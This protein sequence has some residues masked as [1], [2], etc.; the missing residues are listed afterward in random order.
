[1][2]YGKSADWWAFGVFIFELNSGIPPFCSPE[3]NDTNAL[4]ELI[5]KGSFEIPKNFTAILSDICQRL[6]QKEVS[7]RLGCLKRGSSDIRDHIWFDQVDWIGIYK[8]TFPSPYV[9]KPKEPLD[10]AF[11]NPNKKEDPL[12]ISKINQYKNEF[13]DF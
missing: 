10:I 9:P 2:P 1:M 3:T 6:I 13:I 12:K 5:Q 11:K 4:Y 7:K 8:Q